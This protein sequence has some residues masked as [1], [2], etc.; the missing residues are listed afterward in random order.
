MPLVAL[1]AM[2][3]GKPVV[4]TPVGGTGEVVV[5]GV[6]G[7]L[8]PV[9]DPQR[10]ASALQALIADPGR[11]RAFGEAGRDR[12]RERFSAAA[13]VGRLL[14]IYDELGPRA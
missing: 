12:V 9:R 6:T 10:L 2:A 5:D 11:A 1:E 13:T 14:A 7:T 8:V 3:H 4:A